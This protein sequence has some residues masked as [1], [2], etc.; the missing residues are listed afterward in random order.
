MATNSDLPASTR[1]VVDELVARGYDVELLVS[2]ETT[3]SAS[4]AATALGTSVAQIVKSLVFLV[5]GE[6]VLALMSGMNRLDEEKLA[7]VVGGTHVRRA[8]AEQ[9]RTLTTFVIGGVPP[10]SVN[11]SMRVVCDV[12]LTTFPVVYAAAGTPN[13]NFSVEPK[14]LVELARAEVADL[15]VE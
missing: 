6:P 4:E 13:H 5:D 7:K 2:T 11:S 1:R 15:K 3:R 9:V 10:I 14:R 8:N 12:D